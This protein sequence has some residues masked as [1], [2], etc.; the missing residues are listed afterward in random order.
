MLYCF[1][2]G[3][4]NGFGSSGKNMAK[5]SKNKKNKLKSFASSKKPAPESVK[6]VTTPNISD[7]T[8]ALKKPVQTVSPASQ[9]LLQSASV[10]LAIATGIALLFAVVMLLLP[11]GKDAVP[12][13]G[14]VLQATA[15][16]KTAQIVFFLDILFPIT[17]GVGFALLATAFQSRGNRPL[18]R[19]ILTA[20]LFVVLA[21]FSEN[22]LVFKALTGGETF[23]IQWPLTVIK[24]AMLGV[25]AV[26]LS[27][28][29]LVRD[30]LGTVVKVFLRYFFPLSIAALVAGIGGRIGSD[31]VGATFPLGLLLLAVYANSLS[32]EV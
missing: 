21:D 11:G 16:M 14:G 9:N 5:K 3:S 32:S 13:M 24:Y 22:A 7:V 27:S 12:A 20:L 17:F 4:G 29:I 28:I 1:Q 18:V 26:L 6:A 19:M 10:L 25:S 31:V 23:A 8:A 2:C 15:P 30:T